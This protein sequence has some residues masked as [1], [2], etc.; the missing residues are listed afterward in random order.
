M[1]QKSLESLLFEQKN[2]INIQ[3]EKII[4]EFKAMN[5]NGERRLLL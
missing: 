3:I 5:T 2:V 1:L 4:D